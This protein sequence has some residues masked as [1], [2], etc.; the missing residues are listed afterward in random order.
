M[1]STRFLRAPSAHATLAAA[2]LAGAM[3]AGPAG[4]AD[5]TL[6]LHHFNSP[7]GGGHLKFAMPWAERV[8]KATDGKVEV[9][10]YPAMQLGGKPQDLY[11]QAKNG[12]VDIVYTGQGY[13]PGRFPKTEVVGLPFITTSAEAGGPAMMELYESH[14]KD[15]YAETVPMM[16]IMSP[17]TGLFT[18][19]KV[20][21]MEDLKGLKIRTGSRSQGDGIKA[22]GANAIGMPINSVVESLQRGVIDGVL[23]SWAVNKTFKLYE[24]TDYNVEIAGYSGAPFMMTMNPS[25]WKSLPSDI[26]A[27]IREVSSIEFSRELGR[28]WDQDDVEGRKVAEQK[29]ETFELKGEEY[30]RWKQAVT[31]V[32]DE[33]IADMKSKGVDG[34]ELVAAAR[35]V[36]AKNEKLRQ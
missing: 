1:K 33:F 28:V 10:V 27:K 24:G 12:V 21:K 18:T 32:I 25:I 3:F 4:A 26:Q 16:F 36:M 19:K 31:P 9:K 14:L 6:K 20:T 30:E 2:V 11:N 22:L 5:Y 35:E 29:S 7:V 8:M 17:T 23:T 34:A 15:E 13:T